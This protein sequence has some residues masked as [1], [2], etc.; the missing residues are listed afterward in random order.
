MA[1][2]PM[3]VWLQTGDDNRRY[4]CG[5]RNCKVPASVRLLRARRW[6]AAER[7]PHTLAI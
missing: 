4:T 6:R 2:P 1:E 7:T 3:T 5:R